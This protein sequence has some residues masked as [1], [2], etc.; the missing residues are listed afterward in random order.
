MLLAC[1][2]E[3]LDSNL[4]L[5]TDSTKNEILNLLNP[6]LHSSSAAL[7]EFGTLFVA[8]GFHNSEFS[9]YEI[10]KADEY[11]NA[12]IPVGSFAAGAP[13]KALLVNNLPNFYKRI[14]TVTPNAGDRQED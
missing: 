4:P 9:S 10:N 11:C 6:N 1:N 5:L 14:A 8:P 13:Y 2:S 3:G 7:D 12:N